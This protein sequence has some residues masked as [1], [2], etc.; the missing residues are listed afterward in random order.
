MVI[1]S[2]LGIIFLVIGIAIL[3][4]R[5]K[6]ERRC[7]SKTYGK[8]TDIA[9]YQTHNSDGGYSTIWR[10]VI[11]YNV[12][13]LK[14]IKESVYGTS[15]SKYAIGQNVEVYYNPEDGN[16]YYIAGETLPKTLAIIFTAVG[17]VAIIIALI[18]F[19]LTL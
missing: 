10:P 19:I 6:K 14:F 1:W 12:G 11:E 2:L 8:V 3:N 17:I 15:Q 4:N 9:R 16:E 5:K 18:V 7:T 13:E